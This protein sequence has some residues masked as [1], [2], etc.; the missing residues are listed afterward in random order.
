MFCFLPSH[1]F[2]S[3]SISLGKKKMHRETI[4]NSALVIYENLRGNIELSKIQ[5]T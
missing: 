4:S 3:F 2:E 1:D 5:G